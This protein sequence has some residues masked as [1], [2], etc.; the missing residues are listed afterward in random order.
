MLLYLRFKGGCNDLTISGHTLFLWI[1]VKCSKEV[2]RNNWASKFMTFVALLA[3]Y[4]II[5]ARWHYSLDVVLGVF[6]AE[7]VWKYLMHT[8]KDW[9][10]EVR[11]QEKEQEKEY[12]YFDNCDPD[13]DIPYG[14]DDEFPPRV[15]EGVELKESNDEKYGEGF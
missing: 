3:L 15:G 7:Y 12:G 4:I 14:V 5:G 1:S 11:A 8:H 9:I 13:D 2:L 6:F 10:A